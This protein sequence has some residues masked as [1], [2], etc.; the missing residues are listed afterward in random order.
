MAI[1]LSS[2]FTEVKQQWID[3]VQN[4][5]SVERQGELY[6]EMLDIMMDEAKKAGAKG[7]ESY[8]ESTTMDGKLNA[9]Q[10]KFFNSINK[11]VGYKDEEL[12]P[13][14][15][16][17]NIFED[18]ITEHPLLSKIGLKNAGLRLKFLKA[19]TTGV[20]VWGKIFGEIK[21][22]LEATFSDDEDI[23]NKLTCFVVIPKDLEEFGPGWTE[24]FVRLQIEEAFSV[25]LELAFLTGDG[26]EKPIGLDRD[27]NNGTTSGGETTYPR[28]TAEGTLTFA[29]PKTTVKEI[30]GIYKYHSVK[31]NEKPLAVSGK[32]IM[33]VNPGDAWDVK[34]QYTHLNTNGV[35]VTALPYNL[36]IVESI[37]QPKGDVLTFVNGRYD[38]WIGGGT[39]VKKF[40]QTLALEDMELYV[41]KTFAHGRAKDI[42]AT[43]IWTLDIPV[44]TVDSGN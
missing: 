15:T 9:S 17:D 26:K 6:S 20:A 19:E 1:K 41:A 31:E 5:E 40:D 44:D 28:K 25:A 29:S 22:Q 37:A 13:Q 8:A 18:M 24:R 42:K 23:Q 36:D 27:I 32:V 16:Q 2:N 4:G 43:A 33:V 7:A 30:T 14:E 12:L 3:S 39:K 38:A 34:T 10:R 21:G 35:Y 11:D